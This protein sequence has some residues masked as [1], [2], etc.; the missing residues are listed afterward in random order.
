MT[1]TAHNKLSAMDYI[2][3][4]GLESAGE[5]YQALKAVRPHELLTRIGGD[6]D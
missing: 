4:K 1:E 5:A 3:A 6:Y 2:D